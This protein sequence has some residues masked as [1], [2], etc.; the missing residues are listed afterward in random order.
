M[1]W[2]AGSGVSVQLVVTLSDEQLDEI[3]RRAAQL[4]PASAPSSPWLDAEGA[5]EHLA[6]TRERIYDLVQLKKLTPRRDGR[7]LLLHRA[8]LDAYLEGSK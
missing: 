8:D 1:E 4:L 2:E 3:A 7:R 6:C 5:A